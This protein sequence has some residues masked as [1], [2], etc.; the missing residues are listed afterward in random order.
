MKGC[1]VVV[2][3][4]LR[5]TMLQIIHEGHLGMDKCKIRARQ[6]IFWPGINKQIE[7]LISKCE[8]CIR[9]RRSQEKEPLILHPIKDLP[10]KKMYLIMVDYFSKFP[11][12]PRLTDTKTESVIRKLKSLFA[13]YGIPQII[14]SYNGPQFNNYMFKKF[15]KYWDF[16]HI[17]SSP[18]HP[19]SNGLARQA[20]EDPFLALLNFRST[21]IDG[22]E[23]PA[24]LLFGRDIRTKL[25]YSNRYLKPRKI[26]IGKVQNKWR[27]KQIVQKG[28]YDRGSKEQCKMQKDY[29]VY[30]NTGRNGWI[31]TTIKDVA[32]TPRSYFVES[33]HG[34]VIRRNSKDLYSPRTVQCQPEATP[35]PGQPDTSLQPPKIECSDPEKP[36]EVRTRSGRLVKTP[37]IL[38]Y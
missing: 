26:I 35:G 33:P 31:P 1:T 16:K 34:E 22:V 5:K 21:K 9:N 36:T 12:I 24:A 27:E 11:E 13:R 29:F 8:I 20:D 25:P 6:S 17:T 37:N 38:T 18:L 3:S 10:W 30:L 2:P 23:S 32:D 19:K 7:D 14:M 28:Y 4:S 15:E